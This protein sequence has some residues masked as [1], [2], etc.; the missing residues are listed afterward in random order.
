MEIKEMKCVS[1][2]GEKVVYHVIVKKKRGD[3]QYLYTYGAP[4]VTRVK[5]VRAGAL[6][7]GHVF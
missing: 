2:W 6:L 7:Q 1:L 4:R 3:T 5:S